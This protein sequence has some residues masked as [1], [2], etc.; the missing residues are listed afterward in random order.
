MN[1]SVGSLARSPDGWLNHEF[2]RDSALNA[3]SEYLAAFVPEVP[4]ISPAMRGRLGLFAAAF[5]LATGAFWTT[6][7]TDPP[8]TEASGALAYSIGEVLSKAPRDLPSHH[9]DAI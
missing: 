8:T 6:M 2:Y 5:M 1:H 7:L 4:E 3:R 9:A